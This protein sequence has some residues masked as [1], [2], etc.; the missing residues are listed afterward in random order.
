MQT[1][2]DVPEG[3]FRAPISFPA[4]SRLIGMLLQDDDDTN[5][6]SDLPKIAGYLIDRLLGK[7]G[8]GKVYL[9]F[10]EQGGERVAIKLLN[11]SLGA[12][13]R[14]DKRAWRELDVLSELRVPGVPP[15]SDYGIAD[16][17]LYITTAHVEGM[18]L[19]DHCDQKGLDARQRVELL[20]KVAVVLQS[21]H[22]RG[23]IH[24]D[25]KP[26]NVIVGNDD[27]PVIIDF[28][29]ASLLGQDGSESLTVAGAPIG[30][31]GFMAPEQA[32]GEKDQLSTRTDVYGL[33]ATACLLLTGQTPHDVNVPFHEA[34]RRVA[35][36]PPRNPEILNQSLPASLAQ[37]IVRATAS[38]P[39]DRYPSAAAFGDDL[40]RWLRNEPIPWQRTHWWTRQVLAWRR[41]PR[42]FFTKAAAWTMVVV[43]LLTSTMAVAQYQIAQGERNNAQEAERLRTEAETT[44]EAKSLLAVQQEQL[45][46]EW[47]RQAE[48]LETKNQD[49][50]KRDEE[51]RQ[52][53]QARKIKQIELVKRSM[54]EGSL[55]DATLILLGIG[56]DIQAQHLDDQELV[57]H[58]VSLLNSLIDQAKNQQKRE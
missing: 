43:T 28:G 25:V 53:I 54:A 24:R 22:E 29:I 33:G 38:N 40:K 46:E 6:G 36:D 47:K 15:V 42:L 13:A 48:E 27:Q 32:R 45:K 18:T 17:R 57:D 11:R 1:S 4:A 9:A 31:V 5:E 23:V 56:E 21:L 55:F 39:E 14:A 3:R 10:R 16:G 50:A 44:A 20:L 35:Q 37:I 49:L 52:R 51:F 19:D 2:A 12:N 34:I 30:T 7:G 26:S 41:N 8:G 58:F